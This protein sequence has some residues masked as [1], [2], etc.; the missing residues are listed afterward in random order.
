[1]DNNSTIV[2]PNQTL[3]SVQQNVNLVHQPYDTVTAVYLLSTLI[4]ISAVKSGGLKMQAIKIKQIRRTVHLE[5][6]YLLK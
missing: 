5:I 6:K 4:R 3:V 1:M 2:A